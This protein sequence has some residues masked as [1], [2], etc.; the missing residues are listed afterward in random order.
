MTFSARHIVVT[1]TVLALTAA[2]C[3]SNEA[4]TSD[5]TVSAPIETTA[6]SDTAAGSAV[7]TTV[8]TVTTA[9]STDTTTAD[10]TAEDAPTTTAGAAVGAPPIETFDGLGQDHVEGTVDYP[11]S[12][13]VGGDHSRIWQNCAVYREPLA[14]ENAVHSLEHGAVW[15]TYRTDL[16]AATIESIEALADGHTHVLV[17]PYVGLTEPVVL[18]AWGAQQRLSAYDETLVASFIATYEEGPQTPE[19]GASCSGAKSDA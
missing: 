8:A 7:E 18:T 12:P 6:T 16:D 1:V 5:I 19:P 14:N 15:I 2:G 10:T 13:P 4:A 11:Q 3:G 17:S 9:A